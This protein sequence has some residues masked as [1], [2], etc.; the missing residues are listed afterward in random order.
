[1][2]EAKAGDVDYGGLGG[3]YTAA[4][5]AD[6]RIAAAF[7][8][9]L[10]DAETVLNVG[11]G[12]GSYEPT[13]RHVVALEPS[14]AMR[15]RRPRTRP[16]VIGVAEALPFDDGAFDAV[17]ASVTVHQWR[18]LSQG[19][20]EVRRVAR[21]RVV[22]LVFDPARIDAFWLHHAVPELAAVIRA[23]DPSVERIEAGLG[24]PCQRTLVD[25]PLD[26][27]DGFTEA[28]YGRPERFL[29]PEARAAQST[30]G[31]VDRAATE[32]GIA[33]LRETLAS[34]AWDREHGALRSQATFQGSLTFLTAEL[35]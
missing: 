16:A 22:L 14:A 10:G 31:F 12:A 11:A 33:R 15:A 7:L 29:D 32:R 28:F 30:W 24:A 13:D 8:A 19:L 1:M 35:G 20:A 34:G 18:D 6:P 21:R 5:R 26:C 17:M 3:T 2:R 4:R 23:R 27:T 25:I 9:R